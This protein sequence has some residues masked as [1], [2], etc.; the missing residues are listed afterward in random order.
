MQLQIDKAGR[1]ILPKPVRDRWGLRAGSALELHEMRE[2][3][4]LKPQ[5]PE[6][7][8]AQEDGF[9]VFTGALP[10]C[11]DVNSEIQNERKERMRKAW[12]A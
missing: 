2:G 5:A 11:F 7:T 9:W 3:I 1:I 6:P 12:G 4:L 10:E 8:L